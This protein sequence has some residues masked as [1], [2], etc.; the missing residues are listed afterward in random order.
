MDGHNVSLAIEEQ[1]YLVLPTIVRVVNRRTLGYLVS[2]III[3]SP[4]FRVLLVI[5]KTP[6][7]IGWEFL[8]LSRLDGL[9]MG[10]GAAILVR[11]RPLGMAQE[12]EQ[13]S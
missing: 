8:S 5:H 7:A 12:Q 4:I 10:V 3:A 6:P 1:F 11:N 2:A 9:A 13:G